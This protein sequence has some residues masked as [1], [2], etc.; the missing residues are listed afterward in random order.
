MKQEVSYRDVYAHV[1]KRKDGGYISRRSK[2]LI[3]S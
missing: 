2:K 3:V 1:H